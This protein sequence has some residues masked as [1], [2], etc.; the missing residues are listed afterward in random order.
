MGSSNLKGVRLLKQD[1]AARCKRGKDS[2]TPLGTDEVCESAP[3]RSAI[4]A[5]ERMRGLSSLRSINLEGSIEILNQLG[6][7]MRPEPNNCCT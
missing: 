4:E 6:R 1:L 2:L 5:K 3:T 7:R